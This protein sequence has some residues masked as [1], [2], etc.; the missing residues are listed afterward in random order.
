MSPESNQ[1]AIGYIRVSSDTQAD[2]ASLPAQREAI[3]AYCKSE[4]LQLFNIFEDVQS[5]EDASSRSGLQFA[6]SS[7]YAGLA[8]CLLVYR[9]DRFSRNVLDSESLKEQLKAAG[10]RLITVGEEIDFE[11]EDGEMMYQFRSAFAEYERRVIRDRCVMGQDR[12]RAQGGYHA[13]TPPFGWKAVGRELVLNEPEQET[14]KLIFMLRAK[15][16]TISAIA[17]HL[18]KTGILTK[19]GKTWGGQQI[20]NVLNQLAKTKGQQATDEHGNGYSTE[21]GQQ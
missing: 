4:R 20:V 17:W 16:H 19:R 10:K 1:V 5:G 18:N 21:V 14:I 11:S 6:L 12:K 3:L 9:L 2:N 7:L 8:D 15:G 13:G